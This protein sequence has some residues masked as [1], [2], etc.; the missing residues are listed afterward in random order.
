MTTSFIA[1]FV[2][3]LP[4]IPAKAGIQF[5]DTPQR[6]WVPAF[7]G[8]TTSFR[9]VLLSS[10]SRHS[11]ESRNPVTFLWPAKAL[12]PCV[13]RD[14]DFFR[15]ILRPFFPVI[16]AKAGIR[17]FD[18]PQRRWI[19]A[20]AEL[21]TSF[22]LVLL[23]SFS[24]HS[25]ESRNPV[26]FLWPAKALDP[27]GVRRDEDFFHRILRPFFTCHSAKAG[28]QFFDTPQGVGSWRSPG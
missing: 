10:F 4:V 9:L 7:A 20:F 25:G 13:R 15:R 17:F 26:T 2:P 5:F 22:R 11:G 3:F 12:N 28:I 27:R 6:R 21:T 8:L 16:P 24:R 14:D 18:T 19:P 1:S 23:S